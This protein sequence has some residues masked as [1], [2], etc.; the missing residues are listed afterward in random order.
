MKNTFSKAER[1]S[2]VKHIEELFKSGKSFRSY[3]L[4]ITVLKH[5]NYCESSVSILISAPKHFFKHANERNL[6]KRRIR[7]SYRKNKHR[8]LEFCKTH[9]LLLNI[10]FQYSNNKLEEFSTIEIAL[11]KALDKIEKQFSV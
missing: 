2:S 11:K 8:L 4:K 3:P 9:D 1:L 10:S 5:H 6:I 7:E